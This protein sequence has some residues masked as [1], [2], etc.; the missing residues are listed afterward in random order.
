MVWYT[1]YILGFW[2]NILFQ[3]LA[4]R[5]NIFFFFLIIRR[6]RISPL[7][8]HTTLSRSS[9]SLRRGPRGEFVVAPEPISLP[10]ADLQE[11]RL[12]ADDEL[13][14]DRRSAAAAHPRRAPHRRLHA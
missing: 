5:H 11:V 8:P 7:F 3:S 2:M 12:R 10:P 9:T 6:P 14:A 13:P 1:T 4:N